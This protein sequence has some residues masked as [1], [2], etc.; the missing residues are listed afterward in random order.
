MQLSRKT[1]LSVVALML[2]A[3]TLFAA[4]VAYAQARYNFLLNRLL[5]SQAVG[6]LDMAE[7]ADINRLLTAPAQARLQGDDSI[8]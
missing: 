6:D 2:L 8:G 5:L 3:P 7:L 4:Q 1:L